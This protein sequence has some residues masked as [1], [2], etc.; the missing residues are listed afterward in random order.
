MV[1]YMLF[2]ISLSAVKHLFKRFNRVAHSFFPKLDITSL[3][4]KGSLRKKCH[5]GTPMSE[6]LFINS[7][8]IKLGNFI[9]IKNN[10]FVQKFCHFTEIWYSMLDN[11]GSSYACP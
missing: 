3:V 10:I 4:C 5:V 7:Q 11:R 8:Y 9:L 2:G 6:K 1:R